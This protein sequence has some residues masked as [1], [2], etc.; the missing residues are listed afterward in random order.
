MPARKA[1]GSITDMSRKASGPPPEPV[2][3][4]KGPWPFITH[5]R[6]HVPGHPDRI[7]RSRP[8]RK[9]LTASADLRGVGRRWGRSL[10]A[11]HKL[12][13]WIG[14]LFSIGSVLFM[15]GSILALFPAIA[16]R[17]E[18]DF[19]ATNAVFFAGSIPFSTA[20]LLQFYQA[21]R[22][23]RFPG[24][25][26]HDIGWLACAMQFGGTLLFNINTF[27]AMLPGLGGV[28]YGL[29]VWAP[30]FIGSLLFLSS[31]YL[32]FIE[33]GHKYMS[34]RPGNISWLLTF[35]NLIG[36]V[37]FMASAVFAFAPIWPVDVNA[38]DLSVAFT[39]AGAGAFL[40]GSLLMLP[41]S[42][43]PA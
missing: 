19:A 12:N 38:S 13:W 7:W 39:L 2:I 15:W 34:W 35:V 8:H 21:A 32:A 3:E 17:T 16:A 6:F 29:A 30:D 10:W 14:V 31:G 9:N 4:T 1:P 22:V 28:P 33:V 11:A 23:H 25:Y 40:I 36:C 37:A 27:D 24:V 42:A 26:P 20:A 5:R 18:M 43:D 41:E